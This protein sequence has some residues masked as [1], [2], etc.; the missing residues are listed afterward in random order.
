MFL[1]PFVIYILFVFRYAVNI[2][3]WDDY[4]SILRFMNQFL[5]AQRPSDKITLLFSQHNEH[6]LVFDH[7]IV[8]GSYYLFH[9][10]NFKFCILFGNL[11]W[12]ITTVTLV[13][14][15]RKNFHLSLFYLLPIP[16]L[17]LSVVHWENMFFATPAIQNYWSILF[18]VLC[19]ICLSKGKLFFLYILFPMALFTTGGSI[20][21]YP[22]AN[23]SL[24]MQRK[25]KSFILF[26]TQST[27]WIAFY[28]Y[29]YHKP[30][31]H[32]SILDALY[33]PVR[34]IKYFFSFWGNIFP[35]NSLLAYYNII[36]FFTGIVLC[37]LSC[38]LFGYF[39]IKRKDDIFLPLTISFVTLTALTI[40]LTRS[41]LGIAQAL[42]SRYS[43]YPLLALVCVYIFITIIVPHKY[44]LTG[45]MLFVMV[46]WGSGAA[47]FEHT[48]YFLELKNQRIASIVA[49]SKGD[50]ESLLYPD[51]DHAA[52]LLLISEQ[53]HIYHY[54]NH[55]P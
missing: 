8:L 12:I 32:P 43:I 49:F 1:F 45:I 14:F 3:F 13:I 29:N 9:E 46:S 55:L 36:P 42:A 4:D 27:F 40:T 38:V 21:L 16:Y 7:I 15:F 37:G 53:Y 22:L 47:Y 11:G 39:V 18:G 30:I 2:P 5:Q 23:F 28:F 17:L 31:G 52:Q 33:H 24:M 44:F 25:W 19:L 51:K 6:R 20:L 26:F 35:Q 41:G 54:K 48:N 10:V 34:M 50:K